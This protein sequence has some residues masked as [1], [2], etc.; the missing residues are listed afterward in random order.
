[1]AKALRKEDAIDDVMVGILADKEVRV[2]IREIHFFPALE[3]DAFYSDPQR[4][5]YTFQNYVFVTRLIQEKESAFG[6]KPLRLMERS[7]FVRAVHEAKW[8]NE[9]EISIYDCWF[10]PVVSALPGLVLMGLYT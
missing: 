9:M 10:D 5:A 7:V 8:M 4:Y 2:G 1:M 3:Q 6:V